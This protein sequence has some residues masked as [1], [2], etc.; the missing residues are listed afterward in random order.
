MK[1]SDDVPPRYSLHYEGPSRMQTAT[2]R[3][4]AL[5]AD[6][7]EDAKLEAAILYACAEPQ[8]PPRAYRIVRGARTVVYRYPEVAASRAA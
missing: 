5:I 7:L 1:W 8:T 2:G 6:S 3:A 4:Y